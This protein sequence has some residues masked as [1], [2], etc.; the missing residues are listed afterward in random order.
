MKSQIANIFI[1]NSKSLVF[2]G[3]REF[4]NQTFSKRGKKRIFSSPEGVLL[5]NR[6]NRS[7][8]SNFQIHPSP[9][10]FLLRFFKKERKTGVLLSDFNSISWPPI[11]PVTP[12]NQKKNIGGGLEE[13]RRF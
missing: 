6:S 12:I 4:N 10:P 5:K 1:Q 8:R 13:N 3:L 9:F 7:N 11:T 2:I